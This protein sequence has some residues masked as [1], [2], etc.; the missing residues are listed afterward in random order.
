[1]I[2]CVKLLPQMGLCFILTD[3]SG[4]NRLLW[5]CLKI[6]RIKALLLLFEPSFGALTNI[7]EAP[8]LA[9]KSALPL[10]VVQ[11]LFSSLHEVCPP[12]FNTFDF[13]LNLL[14]FGF[15]QILTA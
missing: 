9:L 12:L 2:K 15:G 11:F 10:S 13:I 1:M 8:H 14:L 3:L 5:V 4:G 6:Q 7:F